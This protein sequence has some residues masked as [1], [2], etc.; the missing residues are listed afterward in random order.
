MPATSASS[1]AA[2]FGIV[3][4]A[5]QPVIAERAMY[6]A[7]LPGRLW[8]GGH[9]NTGVTAPSTSWFHAEGATGG[10]FNTFILLSNPQTTHAHVELRFLLDDGRR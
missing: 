4:E 2:P 7:S 9:A 10:F 1:S 5:T 6:F 3:V 8:T